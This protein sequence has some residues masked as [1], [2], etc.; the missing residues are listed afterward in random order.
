MTVQN[1]LSSAKKASPELAQA[2]TGQKHLALSNLRNLLGENSQ[3]ILEANKQDLERGEK[4][5]LAKSM[6]DRLRLSDERIQGLQS[7]IDEIIAFG[8]PIGDVLRGSKLEM[9]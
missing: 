5:G 6:F 8:D 7:S 9:V 1:I 2:S 4:E 3:G